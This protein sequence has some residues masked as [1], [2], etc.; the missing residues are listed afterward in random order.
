M[1]EHSLFEREENDIYYNASISF[2]QATLGC[3]I[4]VPTLKDKKKLKIPQGTQPKTLLRMKGLGVKGTPI[5]DQ[6]VRVNVVIPEHLSRKEREIL[7]TY[8]KETGED[9]T[10]EEKGFFEKV[11]KTFS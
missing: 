10:K 3:E 6:M 9:F 11:K 1:K 7:E 4:K 2:V 5:G 8:A